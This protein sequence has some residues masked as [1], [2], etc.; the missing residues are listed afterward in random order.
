MGR[1][2]VARGG[3][4]PRPAPKHAP[5]PNEEA[6]HPPRPSRHF[7][8]P[9]TFRSLA[10]LRSRFVPPLVRST[11]VTSAKQV[12]ACVPGSCKAWLRHAARFLG[13]WEILER[14]VRNA[15]D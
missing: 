12:L 14:E 13:W 7:V 1:G 2:G 4:D 9:S 3:Q 6:R 5:Q 15:Q 8:A 11:P 10:L